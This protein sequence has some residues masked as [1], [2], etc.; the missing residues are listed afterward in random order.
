MEEKHLSPGGGGGEDLDGTEADSLERLG[1]PSHPDP[2]QPVRFSRCGGSRERSLTKEQLVHR[3][4]SEE[5][6]AFE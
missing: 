2:L 3:Y 5:L 1:D 4:G 6:I